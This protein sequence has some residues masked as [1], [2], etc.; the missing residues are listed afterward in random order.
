MN[1]KNLEKGKIYKDYKTI[2]EVLGEPY[3]TSD[4]KI[5]QLK[6]WKLYFD[7]ERINR[8][9]KIIEINEFPEQYVEHYRKKL[10]F[11]A[12]EIYPIIIYYLHKVFLESGNFFQPWVDYRLNLFRI[13]GFSD[14]LKN[15]PFQLIDYNS[16]KLIFRK[17]YEDCFNVINQ[18]FTRTL[19]NI[20]KNYSITNNECYNIK[21][22]DS[23]SNT[24][25]STTRLSNKLE[26]NIIKCN[27]D[28]VVFEMG[29]KNIQSVHFLHRE[30]EFKN[31]LN[32]YL[33]QYGYEYESTA[34]RISLARKYKSL[35][36]LTEVERENI[37]M[38]YKKLFGDMPQEDIISM[39]DI[40]RKVV[41]DKIMERIISNNEDNINEFAGIVAVNGYNEIYEELKKDYGY[42]LPM[43]QYINIYR[44]LRTEYIKNSIN[45]KN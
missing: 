3:K 7:W 37:Q 31:R 11:Y 41:N 32:E 10:S 5:A 23:D 15:F 44:K 25:Y 8:Q 9:Y 1:V 13:F 6:M 30:Q 4:S 40:N 21:D 35:T 42:N 27:M 2:C 18:Y 12:E 19:E 24:P 39:L 36:K 16:N 20:E 33:N 28:L 34:I 26:T 43:E 22:I 45:I 14:N 17:A 38:K 29:L